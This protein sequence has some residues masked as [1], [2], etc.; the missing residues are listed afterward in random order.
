MLKFKIYLVDRIFRFRQSNLQTNKKTQNGSN[1]TNHISQT[2]TFEFIN[3]SKLL[4]LKRSAKMIDGIEK[5]K[6]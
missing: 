6:H 3:R 4:F 5:C 2:M 1:S